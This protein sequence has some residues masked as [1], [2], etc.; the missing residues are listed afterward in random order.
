MNDFTM[1]VTI[2]T[3]WTYELFD[4]AMCT[5]EHSLNRT[6]HIRCSH[7]TKIMLE[8]IAYW[9]RSR[10]HSVLTIDEDRMM[11][12]IKKKPEKL[13]GVYQPKGPS[14]PPA[15]P[16]SDSNAIKPARDADRLDGATGLLARIL[17]YSEH[18]EN[19]DQCDCKAVSVDNI[20]KAFEEYK[21]YLQRR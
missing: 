11:V 20:Q 3:P 18:M 8:N 6:I 5:F 1:T 19:S 17:N 13:K 16:T 7:D 4:K 2:Q 21:E 9:A 12:T 10:G 15:P 14:K